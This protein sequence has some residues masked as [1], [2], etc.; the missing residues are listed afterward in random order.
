MSLQYLCSKR[1]LLTMER[2]PP[3]IPSPPPSK[4]THTTCI[5]IRI[6]NFLLRTN[7]M[8]ILFH[9]NSLN[10]K[11]VVCARNCGT[12]QPP[13]QP[14]TNQPAGDFCIPF[15]LHLMA[16]KY[17]II[18]KTMKLNLHL[19]ES[20]FNLLTLSTWTYIYRNGQKNT[21]LSEMQGMKEGTS[22]VISAEI[23]ARKI[24]PNA[25]FYN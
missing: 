3:S 16:Y 14:P 20:N 13:T 24:S 2:P 21:L 23:F 6:C 15:K 22:C 7:H 17:Q 1:Y 10:T 18:V 25:L 8:K 11:E 4:P 9:Y 12:D 19:Q 5:C